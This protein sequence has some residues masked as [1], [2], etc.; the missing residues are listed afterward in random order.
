VVRVSVAAGITGSATSSSTLVPFSLSGVRVTL[1]PAAPISGQPD[2]ALEVTRRLQSLLEASGATVVTTRSIADTG[3]TSSVTARQ[4]R[5]REGAPTV[6]VGFDVVAS[7][8]GGAAISYPNALVATAAAAPSQ[9]L[10]SQISSALASQAINAKQSAT[11]SDVVLS[12]TGAPYVRLTVGSTASRDD[13][14]KFR[15]PNWADKV[16][17]AVYQGIATIYGVRN[18][19]SSP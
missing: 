2:A 7:G 14:A 10:S 5:A 18:P 17:R 11:G 1:D 6:A 4:A 16:A 9:A 13:L 19:G 8:E 12:V 3:T 15:D